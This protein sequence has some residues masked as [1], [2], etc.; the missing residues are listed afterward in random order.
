MNEWP[1]RNSIDKLIPAELAIRNAILAVEE[2]GCDVR[3]TQA[4]TLLGEACDKVADFVDGV[5]AVDTSSVIQERDAAIKAVKA[6]MFI[7]QSNAGRNPH[8]EGTNAHRAFDLG[9]AVLRMP[10][11][12]SVELFRPSE[13]SL[14]ST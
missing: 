14:V 12:D 10:C 7:Q 5:P 4:V 13:D 6:F 1:R 8:R 11:A 3:L 9:M 2:S